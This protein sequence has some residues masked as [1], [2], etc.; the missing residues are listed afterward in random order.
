MNSANF[1]F[2]KNPILFWYVSLP[3]YF[4][5]VLIG[6]C[7]RIYH[8]FSV[9]EL[10]RTLFAPWKRDDTPTGNMSLGDKFQ[11]MVGNM[12]TRFVAFFIRLTTIM[13]GFLVVTSIFLLGCTC[14][15]FVFTFP[16]LILA[17]VILGVS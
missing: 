5:M 13:V 14:I 15:L 3:A 10:F 4:W 16:L 6:E 1:R 11:V 12:A 9:P 2:L 17:M 8:V 7:G